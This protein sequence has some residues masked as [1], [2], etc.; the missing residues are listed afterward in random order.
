MKFNHEA[1]S[2]TE[3]IGIHKDDMEEYFETTIW[4]TYDRVR[5]DKEITKAE[6]A[7][8]L[9]HLVGVYNMHDEVI[10]PILGA[11]YGYQTKE[12]KQ[13]IELG[14]SYQIEAAVEYCDDQFKKY[15]GGLYCMILVKD[16]AK[17][18]EAENE[19]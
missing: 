15:I 11:I 6:L 13:I 4:K 18:Q 3:V 9:V 8:I 7:Q 14:I 1:K 19:S 2:L 12:F 10:V 5:N 17:N 16:S